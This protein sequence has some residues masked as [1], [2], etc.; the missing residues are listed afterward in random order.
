MNYICI[1]CILW[2]TLT[3]DIKGL[4]G[5]GVWSCICVCIFLECCF[6]LL[7]IAEDIAY[8]LFKSFSEVRSPTASLDLSVEQAALCALATASSCSI[9]ATRPPNR[10]PVKVSP[11]PVSLLICSLVRSSLGLWYVITILPA[12]PFFNNV[13]SSCV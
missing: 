6:L 5:Y 1:V 9:P 4:V 10:T 13:F 8:Y 7:S 3:F 2:C 11:A 12:L